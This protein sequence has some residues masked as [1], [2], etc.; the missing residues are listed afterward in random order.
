M[1][2]YAR[3][4]WAICWRLD[5]AGLRG[6]HDATPRAHRPRHGDDGFGL[7]EAVIALA[8][9]AIIIVPITR[10][11]VTT[12]NASTS[13]HL[14]AEAADL[15]TQAL[16]TA[17]YQTANGV[18]PTPG[19]TSSTQLSGK[20]SFSMAVDFELAAGT[21]TSSSI[22]IAP[23]G[24]LSSQIWTVKATVR[25]GKGSQQ[26]HV[27]ET[28]L[29]SP[30]Q[31]DLADTN[32]AEIV[33]PVW[34]ASQNGLET[35]TPISMTATG[36]C[37]LGAGNCGTV[38]THEVTTESANSGSSGCAVF[39]GLF[40]GAG[41]TYSVS[42]SPVSPYVDPQ[43]RFYMSASNLQIFSGISPPPNQVTVASNP[44]FVLAP[45]AA[46]TVDFQTVPF[47]TAPVQVSGVT[48]TISSPSV[49]VASGGFPGVVAGMSV[50]GTGIPAGTTVSSV[51]A[52][53]LTLSANATA[54]GTGVTLTFSPATTASAAPYIPISVQSASL[55]CSTT[56]TCVLGN[57]T[58]AEGFNTTS[59]SAQTALLFP[60]PAVTGTTPNYSA[61]AGDAADSSPSNGD[62]GATL[63]PTSFQAVSNTPV[64]ITLPV[65]PLTLTVTVNSDAGTVSALQVTDSGGGDTMT[66][67]G[68]SGNVATGLPLGQYEI[69]ATGNG[70]NDAVSSGPA[71][72]PPNPPNSPVFVWITPTGV[73]TSTDA[74]LTVPCATPSTS[75]IAVTV[76]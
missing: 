45:G 12:E 9:L 6:S 69:L 74:P 4:K 63:L 56:G 65:Y 18:N 64:T 17:Q 42:A 48:T 21:S 41:E 24:S 71:L 53:T 33:V 31:V 44:P 57:G 35:S 15:A 2:L 46:T 62:Y 13:L 54:S 38:P 8:L 22:C 23:P 68:T 5:A 73:C 60:G 19:I 43:E 50:S 34:N 72:P 36:T 30:A 49:T 37:T 1:T 26:G 20:D 16:E 10:I 32:A 59:G 7:M 70:T 11:I 51:A 61:W 28:T 25:W 29:I 67:N 76:G 27:V 52:N 14:R 3:A 66:L 75:P 55:L 58:A 47:N 40:A 39:P